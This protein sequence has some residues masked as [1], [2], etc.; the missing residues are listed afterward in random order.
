M[1][2]RK[3]RDRKD[4]EACLSAI[5]A[6]S[7]T[8]TEW[9]RAHGIDGRSLNCWRVNC[10]LDPSLTELA[11][12]RI[13]ELLPESPPAAATYRIHHGDFTV[14]LSGDFATDSLHRL[15]QVVAAC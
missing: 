14:E 13:V 1:P 12:M 4:A 10:H 15:L 11:P 8:P 6:S 2:R 7:Q 5:A 3:I 9:A